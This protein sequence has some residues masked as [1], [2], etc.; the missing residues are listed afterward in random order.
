MSPRTI[1]IACAVLLIL[2]LS[3]CS[4]VSRIVEPDVPGASRHAYCGLPSS[5]CSA[6][7]FQKLDQA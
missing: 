1:S 7:F 4:T 3:S 6:E 5:E 2:A